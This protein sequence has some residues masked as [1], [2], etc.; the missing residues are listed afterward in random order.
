MFNNEVPAARLVRLL[1][2]SD[3]LLLHHAVLGILCGFVPQ[4][5]IDVETEEGTFKR[6]LARSLQ[7][8]TVRNA[9]K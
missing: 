3:M 9:I 8:A 7:R 5:R 6:L 4:S 2:Q 1:N